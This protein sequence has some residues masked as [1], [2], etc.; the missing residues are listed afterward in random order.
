MEQGLT[1]NQVITELSRSPHG[2]LAD[3]LTVG[4]QAAM[5][6]SEF[7]AH[8]IAWDKQKGQVRDAKV[9]L[10]VIALTA[11]ALDEEL[12]DN[13]L[14]HIASLG[15]REFLRAFRFAHDIKIPGRMRMRRLATTWL[16]GKEYNKRSWEYLAVQHR[17]TLR[18]LYALS[19]TKPNR[20][21]KDILFESKYP[22]D[23]VFAVIP[24][25]KDMTAAEAAGEI[26]SRKIPF[27][28]ALGAL[29]S[30]A[31]DPDLVLALIKRM[32]ATELIT[33]TKMLEK[34]GIKTNPALRG[35]F[36]EG[37][38]KVGKSSAANLLKTTR[39]AEAMT[40]PSLRQ[41]LQG[42]QDKQIATHGGVDGN[43]LVLADK[44]GSMSQAIEAARHISATLAKMVKGKVWLVFFDTQPQTIDVTGASLDVI[45][46]AT[47]HIKADGGTSVGCGL[48]RM[49]DA[50]IEVDGIAIISDGDEN[51]VP[52]FRDVY[53]RYAKMF[54]KEPTVYLYHCGSR[55]G[56]FKRTTN[57]VGIDV[58][59]FD[60]PGTVDY[61]SLPNMV[62]TMRTNRYSLVDEI[63]ATPLLTLTGALKNVRKEK[64]QHA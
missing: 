26:I 18:E 2:K 58:Q 41:K 48:Q 42:A 7:L 27:L 56:G 59:V 4:R 17:N 36:E 47:M 43:W 24:R 22:V 13:A 21:A 25:L 19:H 55:H 28:I 46:K 3:Y 11:P 32:S 30:K 39:A 53:P 49:L 64:L 16:R 20:Y 57:A 35:A 34:L 63:M 40:D 52:Y 14:A 29:G 38:E 12:A 51:N 1:K 10:P 33:N 50:K 44:S 8:L 37:L 62:A 6:E 23:S 5:R 15:A 45:K 54:D 9:A 61:Y 31:K 60:I